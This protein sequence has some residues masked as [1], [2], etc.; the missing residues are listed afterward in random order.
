MFDEARSRGYEKVVC[1][2]IHQPFLNQAS[3]SFHEKFGFEKIS[4]ITN[5]WVTAGIYLK[6][7]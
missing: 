2:I 3:I 7:L 4:E 5:Q 6:N 1:K